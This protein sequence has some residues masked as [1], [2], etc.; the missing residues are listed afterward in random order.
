M[1]LHPGNG[2]IWLKVNVRIAL[3]LS[4]SGVFASWRGDEDARPARAF[5]TMCGIT[6]CR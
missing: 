5:N 2:G 6:H 3:N 4:W 1:H